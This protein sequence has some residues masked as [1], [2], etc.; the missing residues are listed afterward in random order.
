[1]SLIC[2]NHKCLTTL[3][4][5][6]FCMGGSPSTLKQQQTGLNIPSRIILDTGSPSLSADAYSD[7]LFH[8]D[9]ANK[10]KEIQTVAVQVFWNGEG[11]SV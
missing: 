2:F 6:S 4:A 11:K 7:D 9:T 3:G 8:R 5:F 1:M 10:T